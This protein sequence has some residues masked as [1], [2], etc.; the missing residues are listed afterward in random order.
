MLKFFRALKVFGLIAGASFAIDILLSLFNH[1]RL[2][3]AVM[4][5]GAA[6]AAIFWWRVMTSAPGDVRSGI[7]DVEEDAAYLKGLA[8]GFDPEQ[9]I[10]LK[11]GVFIGLD[12]KRKPIYL[13]R[14]TLDKNHLEILGESGVGKSSLAGVLLSQLAASGEAVVVFDPKPD[15]MLPGVL[16]RMGEK[17][18]FPVL[19]IDLRHTASFPQINPFHSCRPDQVEELLQVA[20]ELG[21][22]GDAGVDFYRGG[23]REATSWIAEAVAADPARSMQ[24][25]ITAAGADELVTEKENLWRELRQLGRVKA[26]ATREQGIDLAALLEEDGGVVLYVMGSTTKLEVAAAQKLLLQRLLQVLEDRRD[27][28]KPVCL[29]LDELKY[30]LSPAALR[31]AGTIRDRNSHLMFAHQS[32]GDLDDCPGLSPKAVRGAIWGNSGIKFAYKM[33]DSATALELS[34]L[35]GAQ[36]ADVQTM[37]SSQ[38]DNGG[39]TNT[40]WTHASREFMPPHVFSH[41]PKPVGDQASVG[42]VFG[43]GTAFFLS[44]RWLQAGQTPEPLRVEKP[45]APTVSLDAESH[46]EEPEA[47]AEQV[48]A[49]SLDDLL[50]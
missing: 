1:G 6:L 16:A 8:L 14:Q 10:N 15:E 4:M 23:D 43:L 37:S 47:Q 11:K 35:A 22:T 18:G 33:L 49:D 19:V 40:S 17:H 27:K 41:L 32:L 39:S 13:P 50:K 9:Y 2:G 21:K 34:R 12:G 36:R 42:V 31:A 24:D 5:A 26:F 25:I 3:I 45:A 28:S 44:T 7:R 29:F 46:Q 20:L 30:L 38:N 48:G